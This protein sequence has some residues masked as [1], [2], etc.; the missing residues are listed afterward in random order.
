MAEVSARRASIDE[1]FLCGTPPR[2][3]SSASMESLIRRLGMFILPSGKQPDSEQSHRASLESC[4]ALPSEL[5]AQIFLVSMQTS[6]DNSWLAVSQVCQKWREAALDCATL[7][8]GYVP[9]N[10]EWLRVVLRWSRSAN[11]RV[12]ALRRSQFDS[13][14]QA[15]KEIARIEVLHLAFFS[16]KAPA[17]MWRLQGPAPRLRSLLLQPIGLWRKDQ[18]VD[19]SDE[20]TREDTAAYRQNITLGIFRN[21]PLLE[22]RSLAISVYTIDWEAL[23]VP[24]LTELSTLR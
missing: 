15:L 17:V 11:L 19:S 22:L 14:M 20:E 1:S 10:P 24:R 3:A 13:A 18:D 4:T 12:V 5:L 16:W 2:L 6:T 7:W 21:Q 9:S 8:S 23:L